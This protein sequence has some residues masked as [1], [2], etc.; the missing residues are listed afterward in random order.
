MA[1]E[2]GNVPDVWVIKNKSVYYW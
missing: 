2:I 1:N